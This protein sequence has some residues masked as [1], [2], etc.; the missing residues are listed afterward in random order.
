MLRLVK[1]DLNMDSKKIS[2][3]NSDGCR[4]F[5]LNSGLK[6]MLSFSNKYDLI[7]G[8]R[9]IVGGKTSGWE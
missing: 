2:N 6:N 1:L 5:T 4:L 9:Y 7:I 8:S 3:I